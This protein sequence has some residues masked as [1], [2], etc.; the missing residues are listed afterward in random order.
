MRV[1]DVRSVRV[2][3][4][5]TFML[6]AVVAIGAVA[7]FASQT[8]NGDFQHYINNQQESD[9]KLTSQIMTAYNQSPQ[10][11]QSLLTQIA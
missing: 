11:F 7:V 3:L 2:R 5:L 6:V 10:K 8:T 9:Q 1:P 4:L